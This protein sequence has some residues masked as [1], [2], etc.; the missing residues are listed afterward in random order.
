MPGPVTAATVIKGRK[1]GNAGA[2]IALGHGVV[3]IPLMVLI[4]LGFTQFFSIDV[5]RRAIGFVGGLMLGYMGLQMFRTKYN[6]EEMEADIKLGSILSGVVTT[7]ANPYSF[8]WWATIGSALV[9]NSTLFGLIG[10]LLFAVVHWSCDF[11]WDLFVSKAVY[12]SRSLW[13]SK[14]YRIVFGVCSFILIFFGI[15]FI[16]SA[17]A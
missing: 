16:Y 15:W 12:S 4:Y 3:E 5:V 14:I 10:F 6:I 8:L 13:N 11:F 2:L 7:G 9:I 1:S 17:I